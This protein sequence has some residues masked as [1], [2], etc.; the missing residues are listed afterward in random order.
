MS[1]DQPSE[2]LKAT[3]RTG[4]LYCLSSRSSIGSQ[5]GGFKVGFPI[6]PTKLAQIVD[7]HID[8]VIIAIAFWHRD[9]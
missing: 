1:C 9:D 4:F 3:T 6:D 5:I 8:V 7:H 2:V